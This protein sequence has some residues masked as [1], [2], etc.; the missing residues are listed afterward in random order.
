MKIFGGYTRWAADMPPP[1]AAMPARMPLTA[2]DAAFRHAVTGSP[3]P[4]HLNLQF[5]E[6]LAPSQSLW[7]SSVLQARCNFSL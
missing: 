3:G 7:P 6:P 1:D 4:V 5:R 2:V